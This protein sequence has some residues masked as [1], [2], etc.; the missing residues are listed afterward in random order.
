M[1]FRKTPTS[2]GPN[3]SGKTNLGFYFGAQDDL[4]PSISATLNLMHPYN[5]SLKHSFKFGANWDKYIRNNS[6]NASLT[7]LL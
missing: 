6:Y 2:Q 5:S 7:Y 4:P 1:F 3:S